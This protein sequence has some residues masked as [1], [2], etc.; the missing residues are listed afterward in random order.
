MSTVHLAAMDDG[1]DDGCG[2]KFGM[3]FVCTGILFVMSCGVASVVYYADRPVC[4]VPPTV[5]HA[6][7]TMLDKNNKLKNTTIKH[8]DTL[9]YFS[10]FKDTLNYKCDSGF[11]MGKLSQLTCT[12]KGLWEPLE[13]EGLKCAY[14]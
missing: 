12:A 2:W 6:T 9:N 1:S 4:G 5:E 8:K 13:R 7:W 14:A 11:H 3:A 10:K